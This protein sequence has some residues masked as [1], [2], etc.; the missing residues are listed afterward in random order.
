MTEFSTVRVSSSSW[1]R[2]KTLK[3]LGSNLDSSMNSPVTISV[4]SLAGS[5]CTESIAMSVAELE[6]FP[7]LGLEICDSGR[8]LLGDTTEIVGV[9]SPEDPP[10]GVPGLGAGGGELLKARCVSCVALACVS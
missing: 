3:F 5:S 1:D 10:V 9:T 6:Q 8:P 2:F 4:A 7:V